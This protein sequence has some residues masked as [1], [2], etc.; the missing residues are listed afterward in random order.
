MNPTTGDAPLN[1][2]FSCSGT[3]ASSYQVKVTKSGNPV[4]T[5]NTQSGNYTFTTA[6]TYQVQCFVNG[7]ITSPACTK[8]VTVNPTPPAPTCD[9]LSVNP[10]S[11]LTGLTSS[12]N[13]NGTSVSSYKVLIKKGSNTLQT[14]NVKSGSYSFTSSG[15]YQVQCFV[16]GSITSPACVKPVTVTDPLPKI[17]DLAL[18]KKLVGSKTVFKQGDE[19][20]FEIAVKNQ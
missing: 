10:Q 17:Y 5:F 11:G 14:F 9:S 12:F 13:C 7:S 20:T 16:D 1:S 18:T 15:T 19:V 4:S 6:G 2:N 3:N 8:T